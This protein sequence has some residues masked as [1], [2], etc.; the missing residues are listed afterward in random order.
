[1]SERLPGATRALKYYMF[2]WD[3]NILHMPTL[4]HLERK[5]E[6]G[7]EPFSVSTSRF[8]GIRRDTENYRPIAGD[9]DQAFKD[10]YDD[11]DRGE[12]AFLEDTAAALRP[13]VEQQQPGAPSF[14]RFK[15]ALI[16]GAL[17]AIVTAR[18]HATGTIRRGVELFI[19]Q[20][21]SAEEKARMLENLRRFN[22]WFGEAHAALSDDEVLDRYLSLNRY[23]GVTSPEFQELMGQTLSGAESP[24]KAKQ[25]AVQDFVTHVISLIEE[26][27]VQASIS[28]GFSDDDPHNVQAIEAFLEDELARQFPDVKFVVYDTSDPEARGVRKVV[29]RGK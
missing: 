9:W 12:A 14:Y 8:A 13:I 26:K 23:R 3:D 22:D 28:V 24:E 1:M 2:D 10:F 17:F 21:L 15:K 29:I 27:G 19:E 5:T 11:G 6:T 18:A 16:D 20:V 25:F 4:I 7:W